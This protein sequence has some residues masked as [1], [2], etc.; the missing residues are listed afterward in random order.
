MRFRFYRILVVICL[1][2]LP[3]FARPHPLPL[4]DV[5]QSRL[6]RG[7]TF[8]DAWLAFRADLDAMAHVAVHPGL[9]QQWFDAVPVFLLREAALLATDPNVVLAAASRLKA[10]NSNADRDILIQLAAHYKDVPLNRSLRALL[11]EAGDRKE[12]RRTRV[13][14]LSGTGL[15]QLDSAIVLALAGDG[16]GLA[17]LRRALVERPDVSDLVARV[18]GRYG[19]FSEERFI[20]RAHRR[21]RHHTALKAAWGELGFRRFF[22]L[23]HAAFLRRYPS[24][25]AF[26]TPGGIYD[27]WLMQLGDLI[28]QGIR[29]RGKMALALRSLEAHIADP[30]VDE[31]KRRHLQALIDFWRVVDHR[32]SVGPATPRW[33]PDFKAAI[34][35][36][37]RTAT[38]EAGQ[39]QADRISA[40][41]AILNVLGEDLGYD[42]LSLKTPGLEVLTPGA[43]RAMDGNLATHWYVPK[44]GV[45]TLGIPAGAIPKGLWIMRAC[46]KDQQAP[47]AS[48]KITGRDRKTRWTSEVKLPGKGRYFEHI[49]LPEKSARRL[50]IRID[51]IA[52]TPPACIAELRMDLE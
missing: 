48:L 22:P 30:K 15:K 28:R 12:R 39:V 38:G 19:A 17:F 52:S 26:G 37:N 35:A 6:Q 43:G 36:L 7:D 45:L 41:I 1:I 16:K 4:A 11:I 50:A 34:A 5:P 42:R 18:L 51:T 10:T 9:L 20:S 2:A 23:H 13:A 21:H 25:I 33:P 24:A 49:P 44:G 47:I 32:I 8:V 29:T 3:L 27:T 14:L 46:A 40:A 31:V